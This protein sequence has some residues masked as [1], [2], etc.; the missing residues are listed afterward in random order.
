MLELDDSVL[1]K[2]YVEHGSEE[3]FA[4]LV[5]RHVNKVYSIALRHTRNAHQAEEI[6]QAVFVILTR[7]SRQLGKRVIL[8]GW[9]CRTARLSAMTFV[10]SETR[11]TRREQEAHMQNLLS[12]SESEIW[13]RIAPLLDAAMAGL[14]QADHD[15][16]A[17]RFFDGKSMRE[18]GAALGASEDAVKMRVNRAVE[19]LRIFF[20][21]RGIVC[22]AAV[23]TTAIS[24]NAVQAAP[25]G[26]AVTISTA[27]TL[28]GTAIAT[29][30]TT[31]ATKAIAMT[32]VQKTLAA[33][34]VAVA[35]AAGVATYLLQQLTAA[36]PAAVGGK[37][38]S[39]AGAPKDGLPIK[40][41][42]DS[43][44]V[45][46]G[47]F[48]DRFINEIDANTRRT[49][50]SAPA[51]HIRSL[52][53]AT[54]TG[55]ADYLAAAPGAMSAGPTG[56]RFVLHAAT[57]G[58]SLLGKRIRVS[59]WMKAKDVGNWAG[60][61]LHVANMN[62]R[63]S[64]SDDTFDRPIHGTMGWQPVAMVTDLPKEPCFIYL[65]PTLYGAGEIWCDDFQIDLA[66]PETPITDDRRW[67]VWSQHP[68]DY[69]ET[70]D[71]NVTREG[72]SAMRITYTGEGVAPKNAFVWWGKH[73][74]D[75]EKFQ[76]YLG[77]T[78]RMSVWARTD[79]VSIN[80]GLNFEP[81]GPLGKRLA[82]HSARSKRQIKG[83]TDWAEHSVTCWI[84][85]ETQDFQTGF[86]MFGSGTLWLDMETF[87]CEIIDAPPPATELPTSA[88]QDITQPGDLIFASSDDSRASE[89]VA[90]AIDN[91]KNTKYLN[92]DSG[93]TGNQIGTF[94]PSGFA[95]QPALGPTVVT[96]MGIQCA[97]DAPDRDP[98]VVALEG[99]NDATLTSYESGTWKSITTI[100]NIA[101]GFTKRFQS[102]EFFFSN[103]IPYRNY[104]WRVEATRIVP[105]KC[106]MQVAEVWLTTTAPPNQ[107]R[108]PA[109]AGL[110]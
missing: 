101:A 17:L 48:N 37:T 81:K 19:K 99:S 22:S 27:A 100:S 104:R 14:S 96:G 41:A 42:N 4:T 76:R 69:S 106:C 87:K 105:N 59:G 83:T 53:A 82:D 62:G 31:T 44:Q 66:A 28:S 3:A 10:R 50:N 15:A 56:S 6:T 103:S 102:Q 109:A 34:I 74:R 36:P 23:L 43:F 30:A 79:N 77:Q 46:A 93:R 24:A 94:S 9:L 63:I 54:S 89:G 86:F 85:K 7:R 13:P 16:V 107:A 88:A 58:S 68:N 78:V 32:T 51:G 64:A 98:D 90:N 80:G 57:E 65:A 61:S 84:P 39:G 2:E 91:D 33:G 70:I 40:L 11:R 35:V 8:A 12:E 72:R 45:R 49:T 29:T 38:A 92:H 25:T 18:I 21:R 5:A 47:A 110:Q 97:N 73:N 60:V 67:T 20:T 71:P 55:S 95:V 1:L 52:M 108:S 75:R 26:L